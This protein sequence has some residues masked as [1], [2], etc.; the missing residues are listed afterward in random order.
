MLKKIILLFFITFNIY[1][2]EYKINIEQ[3]KTQDQ[4]LQGS[5]DGKYDITIYLKLVSFSEDHK[6]IFSVKGWYFYNKIKKNIPLIGVYNSSSGLILYSL[7]NKS[8]EKKVLSFTVPGFS[9]W[10]KI[11][12]VNS[13]SDFDEKFII[14]D[15][16][17]N[18]KWINNGKELKLKIFNLQDNPIVKEF[19]TLRLNK[20]TSINLADYSINYP[21]LKIINYIKN[22]LET[23]V[24]LKYQI[25][26]NPNIQGMCGGAL[27]FGYIILSFDS[28]NNLN[29]MEDLEIENCRGSVYSEQIVSSE[30][31]KLKFKITDSSEEKAIIKKITV[32]TKSISFITEK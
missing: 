32:D 4:V 7:K 13:I 29:Y 22:K 15:N 20:N 5:I 18:N 10:D 23:K 9:V 28:K 12:Y 21:D 27:D 31:I 16:D 25:G 3:I 17:S 19:C 26:S 1:S 24:L 30:N 14:T 2:Q 6:G 11:D 8:L